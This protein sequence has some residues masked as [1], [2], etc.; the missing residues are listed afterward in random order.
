M[1]V[2]RTYDL[3]RTSFI[4]LKVW[5]YYKITIISLNPEE[6]K[7]LSAKSECQK[8]ISS[9]HNIISPLQGFI[10]KLILLK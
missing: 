9:H 1:S 6:A 10:F 2:L 8:I 5:H 3:Y 4:I 7:L